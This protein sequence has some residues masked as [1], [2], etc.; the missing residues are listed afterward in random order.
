MAAVLINNRRLFL[1]GLYAIA[2]R[3]SLFPSALKSFLLSV[4]IALS[5][6]NVKSKS[7]HALL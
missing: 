4:Q 2:D 1:G 7:R 5:M 3:S 6:H